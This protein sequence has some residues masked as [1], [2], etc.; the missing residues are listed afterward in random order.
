MVTRLSPTQP[1]Q[2]QPL[3]N[4]HTN[5]SNKTIGTSSVPNAVNN[6]TKGVVHGTRQYINGTLVTENEDPGVISKA[7]PPSSTS[8]GHLKTVPLSFP[9]KRSN[10]ACQSPVLNRQAPEAVAAC[11]SPSACESLAPLKSSIMKKT[12]TTTTPT[13][14]NKNLPIS[15]PVRP[16]TNREPFE[17]RKLVTFTDLIQ[18]EDDYNDE[19]DGEGQHLHKS[20]HSEGD[21][22]GMRMMKTG[23]TTEKKTKIVSRS[24]MISSI[25][26]PDMK[27]FNKL[28]GIKNVGPPHA[29]TKSFRILPEPHLPPPYKDLVMESNNNI[30]AADKTNAEKTLILPLININLIPHNPTPNQSFFE[31]DDKFL[32]VPKLKAVL[33]NQTSDSSSALDSGTCGCDFDDNST[34]FRVFDR[35]LSDGSVQSFHSHPPGKGPLMLMNSDSSSGSNL[36]ALEEEQSMIIDEENL[37]QFWRSV[38]KWQSIHREQQLVH[39]RMG[40]DNVIFLNNLRNELLMNGQLGR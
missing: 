13:T 24:K 33:N 30:N 35:T 29:A 17:V 39:N 15:S 28:K 3:N 37:M 9:S 11:I 6:N 12:T 32:K 4:P 21:L 8:N 34:S 16:K 38:E 19:K 25:S 36:P 18:Y 31:Q 40:Y 2:Q 22:Q 20:L 27:S 5:N 1:Q 14:A 26:A 7:P 23:S 10:S